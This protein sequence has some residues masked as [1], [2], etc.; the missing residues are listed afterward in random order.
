MSFIND[1][2]NE[3]QNLDKNPLDDKALQ[4]IISMCLDKEGTNFCECEDDFNLYINIAKN[5]CHADPKIY[6]S[7]YI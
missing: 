2:F 5:A 6:Q 1:C 4:F 3:I 7:F